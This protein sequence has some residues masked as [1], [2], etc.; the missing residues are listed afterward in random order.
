[1]TADAIA[2][3]EGRWGAPGE[4]TLPLND[5]GLQLA[6][7]LFETVLI[8]NGQARLLEDHLRRWADGAVLLGMDPPPD[9]QALLPLIE[10]AMQRLGLGQG[11]G[12]LR[13]NWSRCGADHRGIGL[14]GGMAHRFWL[15]LHRCQPLF[16]PKAVLISRSERRNADSLL[17]RCKSFA[18]GQ[19]IQARR[20]ANQQGA[21]D[22]LLL[23][24]QATLCCGSAANLLVK[25]GGQW[26]T[27]PLTSGCLPGVMRGRGLGQGVVQEAELGSTLE[28]NDQAMLINS[29]SCHPIN[30]VNGQ[31]LATSDGER[32]W[33]QLL[34]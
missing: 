23:N 22:A 4:L 29:L 32:L 15:T 12:A 27:P 13:L 21:D 1:M 2:W 24:T 8:Q 14:R 19:A 20:E 9:Q 34:G 11:F 18:Y 7:G 30:R 3:I 16:G 17:S 10:D 6:D 5:R 31:V 26:L 25:R 33:R 28:P